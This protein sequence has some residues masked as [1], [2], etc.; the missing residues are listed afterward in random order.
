LGLPGLRLLSG[1][2]HEYNPAPVAGQQSG[3]G[4]QGVYAEC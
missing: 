1:S 2:G 4:A 3:E